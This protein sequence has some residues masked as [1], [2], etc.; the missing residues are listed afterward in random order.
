MMLHD[1]TVDV[2][3]EGEPSFRANDTTWTLWQIATLAGRRHESKHLAFRHMSCAEVNFRTSK[4]SYS[5]GHLVT[6]D[7]ETTILYTF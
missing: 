4:P 2:V 7:K 3:K 5:L 6:T 1:V